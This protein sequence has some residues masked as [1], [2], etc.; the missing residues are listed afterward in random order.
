MIMTLITISRIVDSAVVE[1]DYADDD[2]MTLITILR[3]VDSAAV[4]GD[5]VDDDDND[6]YY[7][8]KNS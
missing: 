2:D 5:Y 4:V 7:T 3:I 6:S 8:L 1:G